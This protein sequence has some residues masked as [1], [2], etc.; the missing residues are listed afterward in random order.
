MKSMVII[1]NTKAAK[2][3]SWWDT[4]KYC[5]KLLEM[6]PSSGKNSKTTEKNDMIIAMIN[7]HDI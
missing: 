4:C 7:P 3:F 5:G 1:P 6:S 2:S